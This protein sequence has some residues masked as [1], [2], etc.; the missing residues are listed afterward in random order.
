MP[1]FA[2]ASS[3]EIVVDASLPA[4]RIYRKRGYVETDYHVVATG[5]GDYLCYDVMILSSLKN[6]SRPTWKNVDI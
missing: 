3:P 6:V 5:D 1:I 2:S 4:K